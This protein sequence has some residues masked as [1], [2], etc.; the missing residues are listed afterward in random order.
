[1]SFL[2]SNTPMSAANGFIE[3]KIK[4][5]FQPFSRQASLDS[6]L[7]INHL[8]VD[9]ICSLSHTNCFLVGFVIVFY[10]DDYLSFGVPFSNITESFSSLT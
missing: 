9:A 6:P 5:V 1:M 8:S 3:P 2:D 4:A 10:G 7:Q